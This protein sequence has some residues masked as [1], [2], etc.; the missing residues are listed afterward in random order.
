M[1]AYGVEM[2][3]TQT[4]NTMTQGEMLLKLYD[5][6]LKQIDIA[7][8]AIESDDTAAMDKSLR[9]A[10]DIVNYLR[11]TLDLRYSVANNLRQLY[12][13]FNSQLVM[14]SVKKTV[15]PLDDIKP[16]ISDLRETFDQCDKINRAQRS[17]PTSQNVV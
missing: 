2:Y 12:D 17:R 16:L 13:F 8:G 9:K 15:K 11:T 1:A 5:E 10:Q 6:T 14:S 7:R 4:V 3:Q